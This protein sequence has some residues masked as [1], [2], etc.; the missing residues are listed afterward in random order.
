MPALPSAEE[1]ASY[2]SA[3]QARLATLRREIAADRERVAEDIEDARAVQDSKDQAGST[4]QAGVD[5][6][7]WVRDVD[8]ER[9][10]RAALQRIEQGAFGRCI[11]CGE[12]IGRQRLAV[13]PAA[14]R[15]AG[16]QAQREPQRGGR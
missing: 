15:C 8:E 6:A 1:L 2:R 16:C 12:P 11:D 4:V 14:A 7:E 3:L 13:Q 5:E 10:V 9:A